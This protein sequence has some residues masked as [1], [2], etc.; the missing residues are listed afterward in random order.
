MLANFSEEEINELKTI[1]SKIPQLLPP[2]KEKLKDN[3][4]FSNRMFLAELF[5]E[6]YMKL[7][8]LSIYLQTSVLKAKLYELLED[9][10]YSKLFGLLDDHRHSDYLKDKY[11]YQIINIIESNLSKILTTIELYKTLVLSSEDDFGLEGLK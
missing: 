7:E 4:M 9:D 6:C 1:I 10:D 11:R 2:D 5:N 8:T 3:K